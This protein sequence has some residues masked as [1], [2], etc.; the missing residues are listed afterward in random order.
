MFGDSEQLERINM[1]NHKFMVYVTVQLL[2]INQDKLLLMKRK[3]TGYEDG[4]YGFIGGHL[5]EDE[6]FKTAIIREAKEETNIDIDRE[7]LK[8]ISIVHRKDI[9]KNYVNIFFLCNKFCGEIK[10]NEPDKC[11]EIKW[12]ELNKLP[13]NIIQIERKVIENYKKN[14]NY[15][16]EYGW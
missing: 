10:N 14:N 11:D 1:E 3:N 4:K 9:T 7:N 12:F 13:S 15:L 5:E 16:I 2:L 6:D 8:F